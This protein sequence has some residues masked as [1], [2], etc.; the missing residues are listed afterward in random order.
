MRVNSVHQRDDIALEISTR[1]DS[2]EVCRGEVGVEVVYSTSFEGVLQQISVLQGDAV[3][4]V[5]RSQMQRE[6][7]LLILLE[8]LLPDQFKMLLLSVTRINTTVIRTTL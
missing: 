8:I 2:G 3:P 5:L 1:G 7:E 4:G 6:L